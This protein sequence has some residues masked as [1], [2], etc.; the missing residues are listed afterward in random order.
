MMNKLSRY[1]KIAAAAVLLAAGTTSCLEKFPSSSIPEDQ[2]MKTFNDAVEHLTG[3]YVNMLSGSLFSGSLTLIP[4]IQADLVYAV[5]GNS[6]TYGTFWRWEIRPTDLEIEGDYASLYAD[7]CSCNFFLEHIDD[8]RAAETRDANL[9][10]LD[11]YQGEVYAIRALCYSKLL[12]LFCKA[13]D[14]EEQAKTDPGVVLR[15]KYSEPE[16]VK[17]ASL[18]D[19]YMFVMS[20]LD[21]A[22][23]LMD[24]ELTDQAG[25]YVMSNA[26]I[27]ALRA[28]IS[29]YMH[30]W[31]K[32]IEYSSILIDERGATF[33]LSS[34]RV[35]STNT[36]LNDFGYM[37]QY[38]AA[39]ELFWELGFTP[40]SYGGALGTVFLN[41]NRDY[42]YFYPDYVPAQWVLDL[43]DDAD[44]RYSSYFATAEELGSSSGYA[45]VSDS[46]LLIKYFGNIN[47]INSY[48]I[49]HVNMPKLLRMAEQYLIRAEAYC[50]RAAE[51]GGNAADFNKASADLTT[52][53]SARYTTGGSLSVNSNNWLDIISE[54]RVRELYMEGF[55]LNDLKRW[56]RGFTRKFQS[57]AQQTGS[58][59]TVSADNP[60]FVWPIPQ[61]ELLAPGSEIEPNDSNR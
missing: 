60:M 43:Y 26:A 3:I 41:F 7:I 4:D 18:Y 52:L 17:R 61:H 48:N 8:E 9:D 13:Y 33:P 20:D 12:E 51:N 24:E 50:Q 42:T 57:G 29:L 22:A 1:I 30:D 45:G 10:L 59:I 39:T 25:S 47:F 5:D 27:Q 15:T 53:R 56:H 44:G 40:T 32:A 14:S 6:N 2:A 49:Y 28:R 34:T 58:D 35:A 23:G 11:N 21:K 54:E 36:G 19:S 31:D 55:R 46:P 37:W 16:P 38:D